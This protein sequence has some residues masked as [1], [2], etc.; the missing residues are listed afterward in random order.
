MSLSINSLVLRGGEGSSN[1]GFPTP[2]E[3]IGG[4]CDLIRRVDKTASLQASS[5]RNLHKDTSPIDSLAE[6]P[7]GDDIGSPDGQLGT[8]APPASDL[9]GE[10]SKAAKKPVPPPR[11]LKP[12]H[13]P[14]NQLLGLIGKNKKPNASSKK[15]GGIPKA[16]CSTSLS[17]NKRVAAIEDG[18]EESRERKILRLTGRGKDDI[19]MPVNENKVSSSGKP[20]HSG[21][22]A[23]A[24]DPRV[25]CQGTNRRGSNI[26]T[27]PVDPLRITAPRSEKEPPRPVEYIGVDSPPTNTSTF[28]TFEEN[29][30]R[31]LTRIPIKHIIIPKNQLV[32][33]STGASWV[34]SVA[35]IESLHT[36]LPSGSSDHFLPFT[37]KPAEDATQNCSDTLCHIVEDR[38]NK[39][40]KLSLNEGSPKGVEISSP[41]KNSHDNQPTASLSNNVP[42]VTTFQN[43]RLVVLDAAGVEDDDA[44]SWAATS[45]ASSV[46]PRPRNGEEPSNT[47]SPQTTNRVHTPSSSMSSPSSKLD[48]DSIVRLSTVLPSLP[49]S[50]DTKSDDR[51]GLRVGSES[52][53]NNV[54]HSSIPQSED[55]MEQRVPYAIGDII[56]SS[57]DIHLSRIPASAPTV[58]PMMSQQ[59]PVLQIERTPYSRSQKSPPLSETCFLG[60]P[61]EPKKSI[62]SPQ[63]SAGSIVLGTFNWDA[64]NNDD[65]P[66]NFSIHDE[67]QQGYGKNHLAND[68]TMKSS[69]KIVAERSERLSTPVLDSP[70]IPINTNGGK[71]ELRGTSPISGGFNQNESKVRHSSRQKSTQHEDPSVSIDTEKFSEVAELLGSIPQVCNVLPSLPSITS[72]TSKKVAKSYIPRRERKKQRN[73]LGMQFP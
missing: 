33:L 62:P 40:N 23:L 28:N 39:T 58:S 32:K 22:G 38:Q 2:I 44:V 67:L 50:L 57:G 66:R 21:Q 48:M 16:P 37:V 60:S 24:E 72:P 46:G 42:R 65:T 41:R 4:I 29:P 45:R 6:T 1:L 30:W 8:Q 26:G 19:R 12:V 59:S 34:T 31:K 47:N 14:G 69:A 18:A 70:P 3:D 64:G 9:L 13:L 10:Y 17:D 43:E 35:D 68:V 25:D 73:K 49:G 52:L 5:T 55:D 27:P 11:T 36:S 53:A 20:I 51:A 54:F 63:S 71:G 7:S 61:L 15:L 56:Q